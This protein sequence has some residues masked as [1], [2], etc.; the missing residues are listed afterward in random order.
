MPFNVECLKIYKCALCVIY[1]FWIFWYMRYYKTIH[2][3][4]KEGD[5]FLTVQEEYKISSMRLNCQISV[6]FCVEVLQH[7]TVIFKVKMCL[8]MCFHIHD[9]WQIYIYIYIYIERERERENGSAYWTL[10]VNPE[11]KRP[12][13]RIRCGW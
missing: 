7:I 12:I 9:V 11:W 10:I 5:A 13:G 4:D 2:R 6:A 3:K 8:C 1:S